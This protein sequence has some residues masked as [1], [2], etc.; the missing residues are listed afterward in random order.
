DASLE[1]T[2]ADSGSAAAQGAGTGHIELSPAAGTLGD[3]ASAAPQSVKPVRVGTKLGR[4]LILSP[5]GRGGMRLVYHVRDERLLRDVALK[6]LP[7]FHVD[8]RQ[9]RLLREARAAAAVNH[10]NIA[11]IYDVGETE[12]R[13]YVA[14]E[15]IDGKTLRERLI[16]G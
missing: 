8:R 3:P 9:T 5:L 14:M 4:F 15:L 12:G 16:E 1:A 11:T 10:P 2:Q 7:Y 13:F 6:V